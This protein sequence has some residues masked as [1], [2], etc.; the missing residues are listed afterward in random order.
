[1]GLI[2]RATKAGSGTGNYA[3]N[4]TAKSSEVN[5]DVNTLFTEINGNLDD[6]NIKSGADIDSSKID[7]SSISQNMVITGNVNIAGDLTAANINLTNAALVLNSLQL[8]TSTLITGIFDQDDMLGNSAVAV[9]TQQSV[10]AYVDGKFN[11]STGHDHDG[12]DS[13]KIPVAS[14]DATGTPG[15][16]TYL[17]GDGSW[18]VPTNPGLVL[19]STTTISSATTSSNI[20]IDSTKKYMALISIVTEVA[21][22]TLR[23]TDSASTSV[24]IGG[25]SRQVFANVWLSPVVAT[26]YA[27]KR[28][29]WTTYDLST[30]VTSGVT[31]GYSSTPLTYFNINTATRNFTG[32][33]NLYEI[34]I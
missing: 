21:A 11:T 28:S 33:V 4:T 7:L 26:N 18:T 30:T 12:S 2:S 34:T 15:A 5:V 9:P 20:A 10:K 19:V 1:M 14:I 17:R 29:D 25:S 32:T 24:N 16:T 8:T 23:L 3:P 6:A 31:S 22:D 13:K 27:V